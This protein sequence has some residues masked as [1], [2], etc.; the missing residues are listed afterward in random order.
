MHRRLNSTQSLH[1][2]AHMPTDLRQGLARLQS[3][4]HGERG[5]RLLPVTEG[6]SVIAVSRDPAATG[7]CH[8]AR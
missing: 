4:R 6:E 1:Q 5:K 2:P 3:G 8:V 7:C